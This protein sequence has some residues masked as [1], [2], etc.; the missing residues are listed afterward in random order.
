MKV[1]RNLNRFDLS[2]LRIGDQVTRD[3]AEMVVT[4]HGTQ[5]A[6]ILVGNFAQ[7]GLSREVYDVQLKKRRPI[8]RTFL[9][10]DSGLWKYCGECFFLETVQ[11][12][13]SPKQLVFKEVFA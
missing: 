1:Y 11:R 4:V 12:Y 3:I 8:Y 2:N 7:C 13:I 6:R 9:L 10:Q 5:K